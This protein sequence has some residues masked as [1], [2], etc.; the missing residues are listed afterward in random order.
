MIRSDLGFPFADVVLRLRLHAR[1]LLLA[2]FLMGFMIA[3]FAQVGTVKGAAEFSWIDV[4][5]EGTTMAMVLAWF[6][7]V[8]ASR[9]AGRV[10][11]LLAAGL[12]SFLLGLELDLLDEFWALPEWVWWDDVLEG[13][14]TAFGMTLLTLGL[15]QFAHE[16]RIVGR[17]L[18]RREGP[19]REH[20]AVDELTLL[21]DAGYL[22][23]VLEAELEQDRPVTLLVLD[24]DGFSAV[25][26]RFGAA[27]G[28]RLLAVVAG[29]LLLH[30]EDRDLA[31]RY[32]GDRFVCVLRGHDLERARQVARAF[33][34]AIAHL[35][36]PR[37]RSDSRLPLTAS[38]GMV[39]SRGGESASALLRRGN[40]ALEASRGGEARS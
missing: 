33:G 35:G 29:L 26:R 22:R 9:P 8:L 19:W 24:I 31:C 34:D 6:L 14:S 11:Q 32:A 7:L 5:G 27:T 39:R 15:V 1:T 38:S 16:Q 18:A 25:N 30:I 21:Y 4:A 20:R 17:Q 37:T 2:L 12:V 40:E 3:A 10:T 23:S 13:G 28:D 36:P